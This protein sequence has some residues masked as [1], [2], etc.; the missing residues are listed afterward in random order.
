MYFV[1]KILEGTW[2]TYGRRKQI[3]PL[4]RELYRRPQSRILISTLQEDPSSLSE[5]VCFHKTMQISRK[6]GPRAKLS[7][8]F[9]G[10]FF[11]PPTKSCFRRDGFTNRIKSAGGKTRGPLANRGISLCHRGLNALPQCLR[12]AG[13]PGRIL[14]LSAV[15][16]WQADT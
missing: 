16:S 10:G 4:A 15:H 13:A 5:G 8:G 6:G 14:C 12:Y 7:L 11:L 1:A 3:S 2:S 9:T